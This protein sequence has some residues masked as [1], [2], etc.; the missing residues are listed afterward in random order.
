MLRII[1]LKFCLK[2]SLINKNTNFNSK[3]SSLKCPIFLHTAEN[4]FFIVF[5]I[6]CQNEALLY[7]FE[8][9]HTNRNFSLI[10]RLVFV[11]RFLSGKLF[12]KISL[13]KEAHKRSQGMHH[14][15]PVHWRSLWSSRKT[16]T[17]N[18]ELFPL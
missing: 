9:I 1:A 2:I 3:R 5:N 17:Q 10:C 18:M 16:H 6:T 13:L 7:I 8:Y 14:L 15:P 11:R 12:T 4:T